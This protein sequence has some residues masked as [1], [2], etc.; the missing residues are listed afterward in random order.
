MDK[1]EQFEIAELPEGFALT[2]EARGGASLE[3]EVTPEQVAAMVAALDQLL[4]EAGQ[5]V[6]G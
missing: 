1:L 5:G 4:S 6:G 2:V 3:V